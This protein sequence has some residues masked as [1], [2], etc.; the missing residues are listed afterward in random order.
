MATF[1]DFID[2][3]RRLIKDAKQKLFLIVANPRVHHPSFDTSSRTVQEGPE[4]G[5][6][7][8]SQF[9]AN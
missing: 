5:A 9:Q 3:M 4:L 8:G 7:V 1:V 6:K 2:F